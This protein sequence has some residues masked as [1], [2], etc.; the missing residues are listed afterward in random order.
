M[1]HEERMQLITRL[2]CLLLY[3][4]TGTWRLKACLLLRWYFCCWH[5]S[6]R[7]CSPVATAAYTDLVHRQLLLPARSRQV[8]LW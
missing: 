4:Q 8:G 2:W 5:L 6:F 7:R 3:S 1:L